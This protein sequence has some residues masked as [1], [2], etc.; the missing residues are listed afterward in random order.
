MS[1]RKIRLMEKLA[2]SSAHDSFDLEV[3]AKEASLQ[4]KRVLSLEDA[5]K[6]GMERAAR[7]HKAAEKCLR[8]AALQRASDKTVAVRDEQTWFERMRDEDA[9]R[10]KELEREFR[11]AER[12]AELRVRSEMELEAADA[13]IAAEIDRELQ[14]ARA[15]VEEHER[16]AARAEAA[17]DAAL[18][19][20]RARPPRAP[21]VEKP[22][23]VVVK[24]CPKGPKGSGRR[25][26]DRAT[27]REEL[28]RRKKTQRLES[29]AK[30]RRASRDRRREREREFERQRDHR[31]EIGRERLRRDRVETGV[32]AAL[33]A[34]KRLALA[35]VADL[36]RAVNNAEK[37]ASQAALA[38]D[39]ALEQVDANQK[40]A[41]KAARKLDAELRVRDLQAAQRAVLDALDADAAD[42]A[43]QA[44]LAIEESKLFVVTLVFSPTHDPTQRASLAFRLPKAKWATRPA[45]KLIDTFAHGYAKCKPEALPV[46]KDRLRLRT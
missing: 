33:Q 40:R 12:S 39:R 17:L 46:D 23:P 42:A 35:R 45:R 14:E 13:V 41:V 8:E 19:S 2:R 1:V 44:L 30:A 26:L 6:R 5:Q 9:A 34:R 16:K 22:P 21:A 31:I 37:A 10:R 18:R 43:N 32:R 7:A 4:E 27:L 29:A 28:E 36:A 20:A 38:A 24:E 11:D 3:L 15:V 25:K